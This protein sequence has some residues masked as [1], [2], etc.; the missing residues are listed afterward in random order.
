[1]I[2]GL[3]LAVA[4]AAPTPKDAVEPAFKFELRKSD[5]SAVVEKQKDRTVI[6]ITSPSG[7]GEG[8]IALTNGKWP[9]KLTLRFVYN[10]E[11]GFKSLEGFSVLA[12]DG[13][14]HIPVKGNL[15]NGAME[16]DLPAKLL[17]DR[18]RI[19]LDWVDAY[20]Q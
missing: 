10:K 9:E 12:K 20:R 8:I 13:V 18:D 2:H 11:R 3:L 5:D 4:I 17:T 14:E 19:T 15:R 6:V 16:V 1:M 7:I